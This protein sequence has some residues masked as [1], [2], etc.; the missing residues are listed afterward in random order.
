MSAQPQ[1]VK[2][3]GDEPLFGPTVGTVSVTAYAG[4]SVHI[5]CPGRAGVSIPW[6]RRHGCG[7]EGQYGIF[8]IKTGSGAA[9]VAG[10]TENL[11]QLVKKTGRA[12]KSISAS[13]QGG[14]TSVYMD[15]EQED[16]FGLIYY[17]QPT[18]FRFN[19]NTD[20]MIWN[21]FGVGSGYMYL[22][23]FSLEMSPGEL[24]VATFSFSFYI[25]D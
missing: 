16:G 8:H 9:Y 6:M 23:S 1:A 18:T 17:G 15:T 14:P 20:K 21:N 3:C 25:D 5:G 4:D 24:P 19:S 7:P 11:V 10:D 13:S 12:Y 2:E 22:Q